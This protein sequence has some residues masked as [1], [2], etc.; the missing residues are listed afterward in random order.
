MS[1]NLY[2]VF[3]KPPDTVPA[4][5]YDR[6]YHD[7]VREN[8]VSPGFLSARRY[9]IEPV[10]QNPPIPFSHLALYEYEGDMSIWRT[11]LTRRIETGD[12]VLPEWFPQITFGSWKCLPIDVRAEPVR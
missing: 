2:L 8:I 4:D 7:H 6:W 12:V 1:E 5:E 11:D 3:S 10:P 9:A